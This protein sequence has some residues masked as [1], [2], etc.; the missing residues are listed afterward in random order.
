MPIT[1]DTPVP[2]RVS[3]R[4]KADDPLRRKRAP[5]PSNPPRWR[6]TVNFLLIFVVIVLAVDGLVGE[7]GLTETIRAKR[8]S[9]ALEASVA[10]LKAENARLRAQGLRLKQDLSAIEA[11]ARQELGLVRPGEVLFILK[12]VGPSRR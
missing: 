2:T 4:T 6:R 3:R 7:K 12:D 1:P 10:N 9:K 5:E 11:I 8:E